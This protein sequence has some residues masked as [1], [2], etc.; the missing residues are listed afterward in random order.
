[1]LLLDCQEVL[2]N[3]LKFRS[4]QVLRDRHNPKGILVAVTRTIDAVLVTSNPT[5][6]VKFGSYFSKLFG[7][8]TKREIDGKL[9]ST[10]IVYMK[11]GD[12]QRMKLRLVTLLERLQLE[13][14]FILQT[15]VQYDEELKLSD[16]R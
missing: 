3:M 1:V 8:P 16:K 5:T 14:N 15:I 7:T 10:F 12:I 11:G 13:T 2:S 4:Q 6:G 9:Y